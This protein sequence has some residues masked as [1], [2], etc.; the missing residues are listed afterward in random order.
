MLKL[1]R[2]TAPFPA[3]TKD[4]RHTRCNDGALPTST[5]GSE[6][7]G[8]NGMAVSKQNSHKQQLRIF[9]RANARVL[10]S[11]SNTDGPTSQTSKQRNG[12]LRGSLADIFRFLQAPRFPSADALCV[13]MSDIGL[14]V[15]SGVGTG[16]KRHD[17]T[18]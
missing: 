17:P 11:V 4:V 13:L 8:N 7:K 2:Y 12:A 9:T 18:R 16:N 3:L 5:P 10:R 1:W 15:H 6:R 14:L